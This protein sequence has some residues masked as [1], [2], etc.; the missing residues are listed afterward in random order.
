[1]LGF[2]LYVDYLNSRRPARGMGVNS[3]EFCSRPLFVNQS[4]IECKLSF[5]L[6]AVTSSMEP[7]SLLVVIDSFSYHK[8]AVFSEN[9]ELLYPQ[10]EKHVFEADKD[11]F[12]R[13]VLLPLIRSGYEP[14]RLNKSV[15]QKNGVTE[16]RTSTEISSVTQSGAD[17]GDCN[18]RLGGYDS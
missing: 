3:E 8:Y 16:A 18:I 12:L 2:L 13:R 9:V 10:M 17:Y 14:I 5:R 1:M 7:G 4:H 6:K 11:P 15:N